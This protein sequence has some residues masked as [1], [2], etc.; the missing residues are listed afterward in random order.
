MFKHLNE[1]IVEFAYRKFPNKKWFG[2]RVLA[3]DGS[4]ITLPAS[5]EL[6]NHFGHHHT[7]STGSKTPQGRVSLLYDVNMSLSVDN[8]IDS[9]KVSEQ[10]LF[11]RHLKYLKKDDLLTAD[12]NYGFYR[13]LKVLS[14]HQVD[15]CIRLSKTPKFIKDFVESLQEDIICE[16]EPTEAIKKNCR[17]HGVEP[18]TLKLRLIRI[19][20]ADG[21]TEVLG[22]SLLNQ[23]DFD[24]EAIK[25]LYDKRW[26][27]EEEFKKLMQ[28]LSVE[29]F[30]SKK[31]NGV[32]QDYYANI[33]M[34]NL[35][36]VL[37]I[38]V[39][40]LVKEKTKTCQ[41]AKQINWTSAL[42]DT[43]RVI[44]L[45]FLRR[46]EQVIKIIDS[47]WVSFQSNIE[48]VRPNRSFTRGK[49]KKG[50]RSKEAMPYKTAF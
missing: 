16:W 15:Y 41:H 50:D 9:F 21:K 47:L 23:E 10:E 32:L 42:G 13:F 18:Q 38:P 1:I 44:V 27:V 30:S 6:L 11:N 7:S 17:K 34:Q 46:R 25:D 28:R 43:R 2:Y 40:D 31:V 33:F 19:D 12:T 37:A 4:E 20:L 26:G 5:H 45:L 48:S 36:H 22:V 24:I 29:T 14:N 39:H 35:V 49:D 8:Q 3:V